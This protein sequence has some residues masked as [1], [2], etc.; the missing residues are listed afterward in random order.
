[1]QGKLDPAALARVRSYLRLRPETDCPAMFVTDAGQAISYQGGR[2]IW[3]RMKTRSG[4][5]RLGSHLVRHTY[6]QRMAG[7]D[8]ARGIPPAAIGEIQDVLGHTS[9]KMAR[10]YAGAARTYAAA[11]IMAKYS[12]SA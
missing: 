10:H 7:G 2:M 3:R 8:P 12:L 9:D 6:A 4:V 11:D 1:M 5:K